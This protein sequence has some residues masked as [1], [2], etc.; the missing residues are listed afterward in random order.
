MLKRLLIITTLWLITGIAQGV[1]LRDDRQVEV[2]GQVELGLEE[3]ALALRVEPL[4]E[5]VQ[6]ALA[7]RGRALGRQ[8]VGQFVQVLVAVLVEVHRVQ[9]VGRAQAGIGGAQVPELFPA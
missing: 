4:D 1:V 7:D 6:A 5:I 2:A 3:V 9:A 8:P